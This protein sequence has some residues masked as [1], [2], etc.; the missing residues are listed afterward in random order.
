MQWPAAAAVDPHAMTNLAYDTN[1]YG[2]NGYH[3]YERDV[4]LVNQK[5]RA[6]G[7]SKF[8]IYDDRQQPLFYAERGVQI[9][10]QRRDI[11]VYA[12]E[13]ATQHLLTLRQEHNLELI[14]REYTINDEETGEKVGFASRHNI[15]SWFRRRWDVT[16]ASGAAFVVQENSTFMTIVRRAVDWI[17]YVDMVGWL[18]P[19]NFEFFA[20]DPAGLTKLGTFNRK[21]SITD[22][23]VLDLTADAMRRLDRR[24]AVA[25]G[26]L[27]DTAEAR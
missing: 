6:F 10:P 21:R 5:M 24:L 4:F 22:K 11:T 2:R 7:K 23:Y 19:T 13:S 27:L 17:P 8:C 20:A 15:K 9:I 1:E 18:I 25:L 26:V 16:D 14:R 12:D 3:G